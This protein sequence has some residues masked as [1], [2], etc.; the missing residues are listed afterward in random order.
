MWKFDDSTTKN[1][2]LCN[3]GSVNYD[4]TLQDADFFA[5]NVMLVLV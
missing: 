1:A 2:A 3:S 4:S 5:A